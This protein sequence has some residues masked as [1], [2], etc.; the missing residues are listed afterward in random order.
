MNRRRNMMLVLILAILALASF[1]SLASGTYRIPAERLFEIIRG[2][3]TIPENDV[4]FGMRLPRLILGLAVGGALSLAGVLLQAIFRNPLVE[5]YTIGISGGASFAV[6]LAVSLGLVGALG[7]FS[8]YLAG[9]VGAGAVMLILYSLNSRGRIRNISTLLLSGIMAGFVFS[10]LI[11]LVL[12]FS[13]A[14]DAHGILFWLM[15]ALD[16][17]NLKLS[18]SALG[19]SLLCLCSAFVFFS[20]LDALLLGE[21][22][23]AHLGIDVPR[24]QF[25]FFLLA[26]ILTTVAVSL[27]G[28]IGFVGLAIPIVARRIMGNSHRHLLPGAFLAGAA[29]L[30]LCDLVARTLISPRELPVGVITGLVGGSM[31]IWTLLNAGGRKNV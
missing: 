22:Q 13:K 31:F 5:P 11:I 29:F 16:H 7:P 24:A 14:E 19:I 15:G 26:A 9:F 4:F 20:E 1:F 27:S 6:C 21:E 25:R 12:A 10:S 3:G 18:L 30:S 8:V 23:A 2:N 17:S 28:I